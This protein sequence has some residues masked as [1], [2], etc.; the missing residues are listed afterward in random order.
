MRKYIS[1][2]DAALRS[3]T[4]VVVCTINRASGSGRIKSVV[5][6]VMVPAE[7]HN[8]TG[9]L[10][11]A[12]FIEIPRVSTYRSKHSVPLVQESF[13]S[14]R[15]FLFRSANKIYVVAPAAFVGMYS[16]YAKSALPATCR[17]LI[18]YAC[19]FLIESATSYAKF[20]SCVALENA[21]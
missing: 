20:E 16:P 7:V 1:P 13:P 19:A 8:D 9:P 5:N 12:S 15:L 21:P 18:P 11:H 3:Y 4:D 10:T 6:D 17:T 14:Y 2:P